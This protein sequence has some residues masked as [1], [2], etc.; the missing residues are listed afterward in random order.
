MEHFEKHLILSSNTIKDAL[1]K[2]NVLGADA[3]LFVVSSDK[4]L[5]GSLTDGDVRRGLLNNLS[6]DNLVIDFI[7]PN[8]IFIRK[9][10]SNIT[11]I[12]EFREKNIKLVPVLDEN[13]VLVNIINLRIVKTYLPIDAVIFA[14]GEG[15]RLLP[16]T[17]S[18]PKPMLKVGEKPIIEHNIDWMLK[19]GI[20]DFWI[21][22][23]Y[24]GEKIKKYLGNGEDKK[25]KIKYVQ[26][27]KPLGTIGA[28]SMIKDFIHDTI[29]VANSDVLT[30]IDYEDFYMNFIESGADI[31]VATIPYVV[32]VPYAVFETCNGFVTKFKEKPTYTY[33]SN[34]GIY[35]MKKSIIKNIP[36]DLFYN[37]T[38]LMQFIISKQGKVIS[39]PLRSYWLDIG[40]HEDFKRAQE[41]I[42]HIGFN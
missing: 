41:D 34:A 27:L 4:K 23:Y 18:I 2:L 19:F 1:L 28:L 37:A 8:P 7:Q 36:D 5:L 42:K 30:N 17:K 12:R 6:I 11:E 13:E 21:T 9:N 32:E 16:L 25:V 10:Q 38:D 33:Y 24:L 14:G 22:I 15:K 26:E 31:S 20:D 39:Y 35:L 3:I 29:L 40:R